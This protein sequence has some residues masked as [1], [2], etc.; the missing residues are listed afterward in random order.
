MTPSDRVRKGLEHQQDL[1]G[2]S[3]GVGGE[4][5]KGEGGRSTPAEQRGQGKAEVCS[6]AEAVPE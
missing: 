5:G 2:H 4:V 6:V 1:G 3:G